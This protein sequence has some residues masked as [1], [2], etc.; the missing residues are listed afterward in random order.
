MLGP[1]QEQTSPAL[2]QTEEEGQNDHVVNVPATFPPAPQLQPAISYES[3]TSTGIRA[4]PASALARALNIASK[5]LF[6]S[7]GTGGGSGS[8][9]SIGA[10]RQMILPTA[11][12]VNSGGEDAGV[13]AGVD[14]LGGGDLEEEELLGS[15]EDLAQKAQVLTE[16]ADMK[17]ESVESRPSECL[18]FILFC[19]P[20]A[21]NRHLCFIIVFQSLYQIRVGSRRYWV[22]VLPRPRVGGRMRSSGNTL[23]S[24]RL[25]FIWRS[26][27]F[28]RRLCLR[29]G[30]LWIQ[31]LREGMTFRQ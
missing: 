18:F 2:S 25:R 5:K 19:C 16:W 1:V 14:A 17:Y 29:R 4:A 27:R 10:A 20:V 12:V 28:Q 22:K 26:C 30:G 15:L 21:E 24:T 3:P 8:P 9:T 11:A 31:G 23:L 6:G 13:S 7:G